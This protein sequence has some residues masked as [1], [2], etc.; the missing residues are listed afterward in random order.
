[1]IR[2]LTFFQNSL[3]VGS[4]PETESSLSNKAINDSFILSF[5]SSLLQ[6]AFVLKWEWCGYRPVCSIVNSLSYLYTQAMNQQKFSFQAGES[7]SFS[8]DNDEPNEDPTIPRLHG[9]HHDE[10][11]RWGWPVVGIELFE[12]AIVSRM[13]QVFPHVPLELSLVT[14]MTLDFKERCHIVKIVT[15]RI[16]MK[17]RFFLCFFQLWNRAK[18]IFPWLSFSQ[19]LPLHPLFF[20]EDSLLELPEGSSLLLFFLLWNSLSC[21]CFFPEN[22]PLA[23][24]V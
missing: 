21:L 17:L 12:G 24:S 5:S 18:P 19:S 3:T 13:R 23:F 4:I 11:A 22:S 16:W 6:I 7:C 9:C 20:F 10:A 1:M 15:F 14:G 8:G 2:Q